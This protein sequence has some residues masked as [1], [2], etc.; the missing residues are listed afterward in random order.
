MGS[1]AGGTGG[2]IASACITCN[3][4]FGLETA[5]TSLLWCG[6]VAGVAGGYFGG[7]YAGVATGFAGEKLYETTIR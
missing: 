3:L 4:V 5:G 2:G 7:K 1:V 6:I